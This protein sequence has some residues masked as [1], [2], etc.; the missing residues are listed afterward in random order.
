[1]MN[2]EKRNVMLEEIM[3]EPGYF[4]ECLERREELL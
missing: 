3:S 1:M 2:A 4:R